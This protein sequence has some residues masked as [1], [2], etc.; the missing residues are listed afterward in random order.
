MVFFWIVAMVALVVVEAT[1]VGLVSIWFAVGA[2]A[3]L[4]TAAFGV[5][6]WIQVVVFLVVSGVILAALRP[7]A[8]K[9]LK[10]RQKPT[11]ADRVI[12]MIC[13]VTEAIDN[14]AGSGAVSVGGKTWTARSLT[15]SNIAKGELVRTVSIQGV[16]LI[17]EEAQK[18]AE[19]AR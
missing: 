12:G 13:P 9:Y 16:K 10:I 6:P 4:I 8:R 17:V 5:A 2:A 7:M 1:T 3:A 15:G 14:I 19:A 11:N 18:P